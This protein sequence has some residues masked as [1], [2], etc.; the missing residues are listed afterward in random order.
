MRRRATNLGF[1]LALGLVVLSTALKAEEPSASE[2]GS[3]FEGFSDGLEKHPTPEW[4]RDAKLGIF[5]HWGLYSV[6]AWAPLASSSGQMEGVEWFRNNPYAEWYWNSMRLEDTPTQRHHDATYGADFDYYQFASRFNDEIARWN[7]GEM[8]ETLART[9]ARYVVLTTKHHDG[10]RLW[11]SSIPNDHLPA[12]AREIDRDVVGELALAVRERGLRMGL[13][14]SG[15]IDWS[16]HPI[17]ID[18]TQSGPQVTPPSDEYARYADAQWRELVERYAP[19]VLW[20]DIRYPPGSAIQEV[21]AEYYNAVPDGVVNDRWGSSVKVPH[22]FLTKEYT[23]FATVQSEV[24]EAN[25]GLGG[26]FGYNAMEGE[27][28]LIASKDL[29]DLLIDVV[30]KN[31]NLLLNVGPR[32]DGSIPEIQLSRL[33][34]LGRWLDIHGEAIFGTR[35]WAV[36]ELGNT[37][38]ESA[39]HFTYR[40][41]ND[42]LFVFFDSSP[43]RATLQLPALKAD[44]RARIALLAEDGPLDLEWSQNSG[45]ISISLPERRPSGFARALSITPA[46]RIEPAP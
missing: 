37:S 7:P 16:F 5:V 8:A 22:D 39:V 30:S 9:H 2:E 32:A 17:V 19:S 45:A 36:A 34:D 12:P 4:F 26:S 35:P 24:W 18:G 25:R 20:N 42:T 14:Y 13:Y 43:G 28:D 23:R 41:S 40:E 15:G 3:A 6:P 33:N 29:I 1:G 10:F 31:G 11:P 38:S 21:I 27:V 46:P 44:D